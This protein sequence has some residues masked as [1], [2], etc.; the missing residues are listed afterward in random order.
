MAKIGNI[1]IIDDDDDILAAGRI[2]LRRQVAEV[3]TCRNP[4]RIP[5]LLKQVDPINDSELHQGN[6]LRDRARQIRLLSYGC[7]DPQP[8]LGQ[9]LALS[10]IDSVHQVR[11]QG[12][13]FLVAGIG[14]NP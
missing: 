14:R 10:G 13:L 6:G 2:L 7:R 4:E 8:F 1:L 9:G 12:H 11:E 3:I 5:D